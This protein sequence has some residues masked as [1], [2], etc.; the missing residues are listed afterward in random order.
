MAKSKNVLQRS[1]VGRGSSHTKVLG[2]TL[3]TAA[4]GTGA[5]FWTATR[6]GAQGIFWGLGLTG[7]GAVTMLESQP[8]TVLES[9]GA[10]VL[11]ASAAVT[12]LHIFNLA[13]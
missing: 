2:D 11:A 1:S 8:G 4:L 5:A 3:T 9:G 10:G 6:P 7:L 13:Q 12:A